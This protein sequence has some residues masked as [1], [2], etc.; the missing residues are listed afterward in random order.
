MM[1]GC[2]MF[3]FL[4][5]K[6]FLLFHC[7]L[8]VMINGPSRNVHHV[9][10]FTLFLISP[11]SVRPN[12]KLTVRECTQCCSIYIVSPSSVPGRVPPSVDWR[13]LEARETRRLWVAS[14]SMFHNISHLF[15]GS[16]RSFIGKMVNSTHT[17]FIINSK[18]WS[19]PTAERHCCDPRILH[20]NATRVQSQRLEA[21]NI[22]VNSRVTLVLRTVCL[23][24]LE[25]NTNLRFIKYN[26]IVPDGK[27]IVD[28]ISWAQATILSTWIGYSSIR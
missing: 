18:N 11:K 7:A 1:C 23:I 21:P 8:L 20:F 25:K 27:S 19:S 9:V 5:C 6:M 2:K 28:F 24:F 14:S 22:L 4:G 3:L 16:E 17:Q 12:Y 26:A 13:T 10:I 15:S